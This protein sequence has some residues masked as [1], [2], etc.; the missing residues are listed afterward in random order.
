M[1]GSGAPAPAYWRGVCR[2]TALEGQLVA[3]FQQG[4][5]PAED[6][7]PPAPSALRLQRAGDERC[8]PGRT[9]Q[10]MGDGELRHTAATRRDLVREARESL[11]GQAR[12]RARA[13][14]LNQVGRRGRFEDL[15]VHN[16]ARHTAHRLHAGIA[17]DGE[18][19]A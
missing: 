2:Q 14:A 17:V 11:C 6:P 10:I 12:I 9:G 1:A 13:L 16:H 4:F 8:Q 18:G 7:V 3:G 5:E 15:A 19:A